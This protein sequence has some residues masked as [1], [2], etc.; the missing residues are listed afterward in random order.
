MAS[1]EGGALKSVFG[2][3]ASGL[4]ER[5]DDARTPVH[6]LVCDRGSVID[7]S[8]R[9]MRLTSPRRWTEGQHRRIIITDGVRS[10]AIEARCVWC[11]QDGLFSHAVGLAFEEIDADAEDVLRHFERVC[12]SGHAIGMRH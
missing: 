1:S 9:G 10:A 4:K 2:R 7:L 12:A 8:M 11:R 6:G 3:L 5:R